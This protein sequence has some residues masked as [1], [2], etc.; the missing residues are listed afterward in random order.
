MIGRPLCEQ[1]NSSRRLNG[2]RIYGDDFA[3]VSSLCFC[4]L[5]LCYGDHWKQKE[6]T[7]WDALREYSMYT[8]W[9]VSL[10][11]LL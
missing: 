6:S 1:S 10:E 3:F 4:D 5:F 2:G 9:T 8:A 11:G 7:E